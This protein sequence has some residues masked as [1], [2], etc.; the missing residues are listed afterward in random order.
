MSL[1]EK[2]LNNINIYA[3]KDYDKFIKDYLDD[4]PL[5]ERV[6]L[7]DI[8]YYDSDIDFDIKNYIKEHPEKYL[9]WTIELDELSDLNDS[10]GDSH[11]IPEYADIDQR[12][13]AFIIINHEVL[14]DTDAAHT[15]LLNEYLEENYFETQEHPSEEELNE[16]NIDC[17]FGA[18]VGDV[19]F[20]D[21]FNCP[22]EEIK[23]DLSN[24][25][26]KPN[27]FY[28]YSN[29]FEITRVV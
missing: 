24:A 14:I 9:P 28:V 1:K 5:S 11:G 27:K 22:I 15:D 25:G 3:N 2:I 12:D 4:S 21:E 6:A 20:L 16:L 19:C 7:D 29:E 18:L 13:S 17:V 26:I 8:L 10:V 23:E